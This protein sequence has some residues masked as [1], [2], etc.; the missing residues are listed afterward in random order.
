MI[1][2]YLGLKT[3][4]LLK[5]VPKN[6]E[7]TIFSDNLKKGLH[8]KEFD[9]FCKEY[10]DVTISFKK[11]SGNFHDRYIIIDFGTENEI[12]YHCGASSKDAGGRICSITTIA[13][14]T[15]YDPIIRNLLQN[16]DLIL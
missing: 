16:Q 4:I 13:D 10:P 12:I 5:S 6:V 7:V 1:D 9:D 2:N 15:I 3:L 14:N 11:T 8:Q